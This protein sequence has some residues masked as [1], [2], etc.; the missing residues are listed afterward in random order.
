MY[1]RSRS[2]DAGRF[3]WKALVVVIVIDTS[4]TTATAREL[5]VMANRLTGT[6]LDVPLSK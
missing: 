4:E 3:V 2:S 1:V 5:S 6:G